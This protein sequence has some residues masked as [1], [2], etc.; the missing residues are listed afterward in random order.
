[1]IS[2]SISSTEIM[3]FSEVSLIE[4]SNNQKKVMKE[5]NNNNKRK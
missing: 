1:M 2:I 3:G 4:N 5:K